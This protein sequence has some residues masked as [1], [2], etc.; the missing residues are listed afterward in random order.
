MTTGASAP[1]RGDELAAALA[2]VRVRV[3]LVALLMALAAGGWW[4]SVQQMDGMDD[5]PWTTLGSFSWFITVWVVMMAAM[6]PPSV[7]PTVALY[8]KMTRSRTP[9]APLAFDTEL[10]PLKDV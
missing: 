2:A 9:Y 7:A 8:A 10:T 5:G 4:W 6:M 1:T 3:G